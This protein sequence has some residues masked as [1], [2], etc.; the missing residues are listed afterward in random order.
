MGINITATNSKYSFDMGY[1]GFYHLRKNIALAYDKDFGKHYANLIYCHTLKE[2]EKHDRIS[3][4]IINRLDPEE[5]DSDI[6]DFLYASDCEGK[7]SYKTCKKI[8]DLIKDI[9]FGDKSFIYSSLS[10]G[11]DYEYFKSF[12]KECYT[13]KRQM[14]WR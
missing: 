6:F 10:D 5:K 9:D 14:R 7:I 1:G 3:E 13:H 11:K 8:Y 12:L 4:K 2:F